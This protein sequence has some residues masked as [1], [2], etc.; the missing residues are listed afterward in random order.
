[1]ASLHQTRGYEVRID[2]VSGSALRSQDREGWS[3][4]KGVVKKFALVTAG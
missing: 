2:L 1:M 4:V 3:A